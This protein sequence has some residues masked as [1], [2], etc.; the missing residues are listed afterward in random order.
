MTKMSCKISVLEEICRLASLKGKNPQGKEYVAIPDFLLS[1]SND[2]MVCVKAVDSKGAIA[3]DLAYK[4][5][6]VLTPGVIPI[7]DVEKFVKYLSRFNSSDE[8]TVETTENR[9]ILERKEPYKKATIPMASV[10]SISSNKNAEQILSNFQKTETGFFKSKKTNLNI[11]LTLN[12]DDIKSVIDDGEV[13]GQR[14]YPWQLAGN[15]LFI[16][17]GSEQ[18]GE[19]ETAIPIIKRDRDYKPVEGEEDPGYYTKTSFAYGVDNIFGNLSGEIQIYLANN[20]EVCPLILTKETDTYKLKI[21]L[22]PVMV[23]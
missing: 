21:L 7:G 22:A 10:D 12:A 13:V 14:I 6:N 8:V 4:G 9:I 20:A 2:K 1:V 11:R 16:K 23:E 19:I 18:L 3:V 5:I 15:L 17:V